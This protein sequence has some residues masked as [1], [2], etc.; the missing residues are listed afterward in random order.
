METLSARIKFGF[1]SVFNPTGQ[2]EVASLLNLF[3]SRVFYTTPS[4]FLLD[5]TVCKVGSVLSPPVPGR[6]WV[7]FIPL[8]NL[9]PVMLDIVFPDFFGLVFALV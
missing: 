8:I 7:V 4:E 5:I 6:F 2:N 9:R 3:R 1:Q